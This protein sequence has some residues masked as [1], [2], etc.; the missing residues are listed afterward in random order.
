MSKEIAFTNEELIL[1]RQLI[2][3]ESPRS[4]ENKKFIE[5]LNKYQVD[6][7]G[8]LEAYIKEMEYIHKEVEHEMSD[9][10][11]TYDKV[12]EM[13]KEYYNLPVNWVE[14]CTRKDNVITFDFNCSE[15]E[16][17]IT[18]IYDENLDCVKIESDFPIILLKRNN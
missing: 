9:I 3:I 1:I 13:L 12:S 2:D 15:N 4:R 6:W 5:L 16:V 17:N 10:I 7:I 8:I 11:I 18:V 14:S